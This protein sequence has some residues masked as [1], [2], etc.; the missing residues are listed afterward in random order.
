MMYRWQLE[1]GCGCPG[2]Y[3]ITLSTHERMLLDIVPAAFIR[4]KAVRRRLPM[5][6]GMAFGRDSACELAAR[7]ISDVYDKTAGVDVRRFFQ[8]ERQKG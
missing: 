4:Q 8:E 3:V 2:M 7:V 6:I 1:H 5:I